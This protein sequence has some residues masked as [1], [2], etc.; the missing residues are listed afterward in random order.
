MN[1]LIIDDHPM[2]VEGYIQSLSKQSLSTFKTE[3]YKA[4]DC[5]QALNTIRNIHCSQKFLDLIIMDY[6]LP[7]YEKEEILSGSDLALFI[8]IIMPNTKILT[9]I[10]PVV[11]PCLRRPCRRIL[12]TWLGQSRPKYQ[13]PLG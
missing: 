5:E 9:L 1:V 6:G 3:F 2:T 12:R 7:K 13:R 11:A 4:Y 8:K 10:A